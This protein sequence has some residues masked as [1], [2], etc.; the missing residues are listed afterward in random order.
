MDT[1]TKKR[2]IKLF[3]YEGLLD[4]LDKIDSNVNSEDNDIN[5]AEAVKRLR[6]CRGMSRKEFCKYI[7]V[8]YRTLQDWELGN[9]SMPPYMLRLLAYAVLFDIL[10]RDNDS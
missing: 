5:V 10:P 3:D 6:E 2:D 7:G 1:P 4:K 8:P 9:R